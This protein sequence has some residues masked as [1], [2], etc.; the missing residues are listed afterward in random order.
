MAYVR[1][2]ILIDEY[3]G[4]NGK[5]YNKGAVLTVFDS[6]ELR[7]LVVIGKIKILDE[8]QTSLNL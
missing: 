3:P 7:D 6:L 5:V 1:I 4:N 8:K 2:E